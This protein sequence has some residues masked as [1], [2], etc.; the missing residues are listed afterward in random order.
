MVDSYLCSASHGKAIMCRFAAGGWLG[1]DLIGAAGVL[2][3][4]Q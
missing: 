2:D 3:D 1:N 4:K